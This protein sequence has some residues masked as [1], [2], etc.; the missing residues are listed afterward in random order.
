MYKDLILSK[1]N[2]IKNSIILAYKKKEPI[3]GEFAGIFKYKKNYIV[4]RDHI[5]CK[6]FFFIFKNKK[7]YT[8]NNFIDLIKYGEDF[9]QSVEPGFYTEINNNGKVINKTQIPKY[10][11]KNKRSENI[12]KY[13]KFI[14]KKYGKN[15]IVCLS[16]GLDSTI[17]AYYAKKIFDNVNLITAYFDKRENNIN[18]DFISSK[19]IGKFLNLKHYFVKV[20][21]TRIIKNIKKIMY[22][23]QDWR[24]YNLHCSCLNFILGEF[25]KKNTSLKNKVILTGDFMNEFVADY[26]SEKVYG[27][28]FYRVPN[29][30][31]KT[32]QRFFTRGLDTSS[33]ESG[34]FDFFGL[35]VFQ[36]FN[37]LKDFYF[38]FDE[39]KISQNN[40][41]Y[42]INKTLI[43][44][45]LFNLVNKKKVRAQIGDE[46]SGGIIKIFH[47]N[48]IYQ[49]KLEEIF[50]KNFNC[51]SEWL[52]SFIQF[53][54]FKY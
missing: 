12:E 2:S 16:G 26:T 33:R 35:R 10:T 3:L 24:D 27:K 14:K 53:G 7:L 8:S 9:I 47:K 25:I 28:I 41:K 44:K 39:K 29:L 45:S 4:Y 5:G 46:K 6:K 18:S 31:K 43:P 13:L 30:P 23:C 40:F 48:K 50:V 51:S 19:K 1:N 54:R 20:D 38:K 36:P 49:K 21:N 22:A 11:I 17:I 52:R 42:N 34:V 37:C 32:L 15:C